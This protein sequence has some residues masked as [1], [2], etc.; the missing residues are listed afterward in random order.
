M[1]ALGNKKRH[2][3]LFCMGVAFLSYEKNM[4]SKFQAN[5]KP[6]VIVRNDRCKFSEIARSYLY[7]IYY[8]LSTN[9]YVSL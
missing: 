9:L 2:K 4:F 3:V 5:P 8:L 6:I 7:F 1:I